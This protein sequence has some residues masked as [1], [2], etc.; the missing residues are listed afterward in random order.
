[1]TQ[2]YRALVRDALKPGAGKGAEKRADGGDAE[3]TVA[4]RQGAGVELQRRV[5]GINPLLGAA[6]VLLALVPQLRATTSHADPAGLQR[7]LLARVEGIRNRRAG[8]RRAAAESDRRALRAVHVHRRGDGVDAVGRRAGP[9]PS[10]TCCRNSTTNATAAKKRSS[11]SSAWVKTS[12]RTSTC[13]NCST[14]ASRSA[15]RAV[16]AARPTG[17]HN[18]TRSPRVWSTCCGRRTASRPRARCRCAG[19]ASRCSAAARCPYCRSGPS[20]RLAP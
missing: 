6:N 12:R 17:A 3:A 13:L 9:G 1:M 8:E 2:D 4:A 15:S 16:I 10:T 11:C 5:A 7:Q 14:S 20:L 18:S 19:P